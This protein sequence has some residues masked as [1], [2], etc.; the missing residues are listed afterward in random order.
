MPD[1]CECRIKQRNDD[2][3]K[4]LI[5]RLSRIEGQ[6]RGIK[7]MVET[8][9]YCIDILN[10]VAAASAAMNSFS[11][12]LLS[13]HIKSCVVNDVAAGNSDKIEELLKMLPKLMK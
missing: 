11:K 2:E 9:V 4:L 1:K 13:D 5:N 7:T 6:I 12:E 10:Q 3:K 8:N